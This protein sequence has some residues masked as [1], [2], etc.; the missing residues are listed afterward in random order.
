MTEPPLSFRV[1]SLLHTYRH[2]QKINT[3][4]LYDQDKPHK[5]EIL[6]TKPGP[7]ASLFNVNFVYIE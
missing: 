7:I 3:D 5:L 4:G 6:L 1:L 2:T